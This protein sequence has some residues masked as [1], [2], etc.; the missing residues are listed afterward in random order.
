[1]G[2]F[3]VDM[4]HEP[5]IGNDGSWIYD[6]EDKI[7]NVQ[8]RVIRSD[9]HNYHFAEEDTFDLNLMA[10][11]FESSEFVDKNESRVQKNY[12]G[13]PTLDCKYRDKNG[14]IFLARFIIQGPHYYTL[15]A[16][17][18]HP[19][20]AMDKFLNSFEIQTFQY[21]LSK[22]RK[23]T[24]LYYTVKSP[25]FPEAAK[26]KLDI[27]KYSSSDDDDE[28]VENDLLENGAFRSRIISNDSTG[29]KIFVSFFK[30]QRYTYLK[31]ST[32]LDKENQSLLFSDSSGIVKLKK[33]FELPNKI[34]VWETVLTDTGS[35]RTI[36][37]KVF[38]KN[39]IGYALLTQSDTLSKPSSFVQTF[40][41]SFVPADTLA[42]IDPFTKKTATFFADYMSAD[43][44]AHKRAV[45]N[46]YSIKLDSADLGPLKKAIAFLDWK[47]KKYL[48][49][50]KDLVSKL[51]DIKSRQASDYLQEL[52]Y[53]A[54]DTVE[55]Q[56]K[57]L[58]VL[59]QQKTPYSYKLFKD[60]MLNEPP[61]LG[62][63]RSTDY[64]SVY[65]SEI[66]TLARIGYDDGNFIDELHDSLQLTK[67]IL[68]ELLPLLNLDD[69]KYSM[70]QLLAEMVDSN[71]VKPKD[72]DIYFSKFLI[73]T[74]QELK[75]QAI[76][77]KQKAISK[78][79]ESKEDKKDSSNDYDND[80]SNT[81]NQKLQL[82]ATLLLPYWDMNPAVPSLFKQ[83][84]SSG[85]RKLNYGIM[86]LLV[87]NGKPYPDSL[88]KYFASMDNYR[89]G[90]YTDLREIG[91]EKQFPALYNNH[92]DLAKS[93]L[94]AKKS[95]DK[96]DSVVYLD[97]LDA[98][99]KHRK[100][101]IYFFKYKTK[102]DDA[103][104]KIASVGL[105]PQDIKQF[106][107]EEKEK[108]SPE[109]SSV[110]D[111]NTGN[112]SYDVTAFTDTKLRPDEPVINQLKK[113]RKK[114]LYSV[115]KSAKEFYDKDD[116]DSYETDS[117]VDYEN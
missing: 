63:G 7:N 16:H 65:A 46:I 15:V 5:N 10:E 53:A 92:I 77:E 113:Q 111:N 35:S 44:V 64:T 101:Y 67:T 38:Y 93:K 52:Y 25:V 86:L 78:A 29:E 23:D 88:L 43:S 76:A 82:Y 51:D 58:E 79:E 47:E 112:S 87:R 97:R 109:Y 18:K 39:G 50:K 74:R 41:E 104:W 45:K 105:V 21:N 59:L 102:K 28:L 94:L 85:D 81:G 99:V 32:L 33:K 30:M 12:K 48:E 84:L 107:F 1:M 56:H 117:A 9:I 31:D 70:M 11:S 80:D 60:I 20:A 83:L 71:L 40:F 69:Y 27:P 98:Q 72:Y 73:E 19:T 22:E 54:G 26:A 106:E 108:K 14:G 37:S 66:K 96:P 3:C 95:Y 61:V 90:L 91:M 103:S 116:S 55:L 114:L 89:Y 110:Y 115:R 24:S 2:G 17:G 68:P 4:P 13:Y 8:Y 34:K 49:V 75:R 62:I 100:G 57:A 42:G 6:A 36:W